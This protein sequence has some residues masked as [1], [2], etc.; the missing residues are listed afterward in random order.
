VALAGLV[1]AVAFAHR[2]TALDDHDHVF[3]AVAQV[4]TTTKTAERISFYTSPS[5]HNMRSET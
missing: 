4:G 2:D 5:P 3:D 1:D